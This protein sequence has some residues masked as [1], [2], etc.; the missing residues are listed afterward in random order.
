LRA[1][2]FE[3]DSKWAVTLWYAFGYGETVIRKAVTEI[4]NGLV[5]PGGAPIAHAKR[6]KATVND[7][8]EIADATSGTGTPPKT[9]VENQTE[10]VIVSTNGY[11]IETELALPVDPLVKVSS[12]DNCIETV[13]ITVQDSEAFVTVQ[14]SEALGASDETDITHTML[15]TRPNRI[16]YSA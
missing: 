15:K 12:V 2:L 1:I 3:F 14:D 10:Q 6:L 7:D 16:T 11:S 5:Y 9:D 8:T 4:V 13:W